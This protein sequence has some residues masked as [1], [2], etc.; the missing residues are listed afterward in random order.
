MVSKHVYNMQLYKYCCSGTCVVLWIHTLPC[1]EACHKMLMKSKITLYPYNSHGTLHAV[2]ESDKPH[3]YDCLVYTMNVNLQY[4][5]MLYLYIPFKLLT[6]SA[7][8]ELHQLPQKSLHTG[9]IT[10]LAVCYITHDI[11]LCCV[12]FM[13]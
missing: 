7:L 3:T 9:F 12:M 2:C 11:L 4:M 1:K 5:C 6:F 8:I 13:Q 10:C